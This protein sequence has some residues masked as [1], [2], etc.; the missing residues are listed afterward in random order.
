MLENLHVG[1]SIFYLSNTDS[2]KYETAIPTLSMFIIADNALATRLVS[3]FTCVDN[4]WYYY[5]QQ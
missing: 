3:V 2:A 1:D 4:R 5:W